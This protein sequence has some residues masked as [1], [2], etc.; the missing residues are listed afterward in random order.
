MYFKKENWEQT[1]AVTANLIVPHLYKKR[2]G[3]PASHN[4]AVLER[5]RTADSSGLGARSE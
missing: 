4:S 3:R 5:R 2:K 1:E